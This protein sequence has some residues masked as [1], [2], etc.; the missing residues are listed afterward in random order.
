MPTKI[1]KKVYSVRYPGELHINRYS[2]LDDNNL[3][4]KSEHWVIKDGEVTKY[5][6]RN[7]NDSNRNHYS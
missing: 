1:I 6:Q 5:I 3:H 7:N 2:F 4:F